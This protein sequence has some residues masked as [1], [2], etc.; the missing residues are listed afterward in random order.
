MIKRVSF[1]T[2]IPE[3]G[4]WVSTAGLCFPIGFDRL[5]ETAVFKGDENGITDWNELHLVPHGYTIDEEF[6]KREHDRIVR[7][8]KA[9]K[10]KLKGKEAEEE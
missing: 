8:I 10:L 1:K 4:V 5:A 3:K 2:Y 6:L 9:G 7:E